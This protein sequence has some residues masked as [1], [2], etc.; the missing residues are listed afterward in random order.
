MLSRSRK[1]DSD[2]VYWPV[3]NDETDEFENMIKTA[4]KTKKDKIIARKQ[5]AIDKRDETLFNWLRKMSAE[6]KYSTIALHD[7]ALK[8]NAI[9]DKMRADLDKI[10]RL[11]LDSPE[12]F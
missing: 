7:K 3:R 5:R 4:R 1:E 2:D 12:F 11:P 9:T 8:Y 10:K 6:E